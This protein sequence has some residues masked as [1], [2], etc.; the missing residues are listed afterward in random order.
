MHLHFFTACKMR[1]FLKWRRH[2]PNNTKHESKLHRFSQYFSRNAM[3]F[4]V[5]ISQ[6]FFRNSWMRP[7]RRWSPRTRE[8]Q[9]PWYGLVMK[10]L[11]KYW[12]WLIY[13]YIYMYIYIYSSS[14]TSLSGT[15]Q[16]LQLCLFVAVPFFGFG[17]AD[18]ATLVMQRVSE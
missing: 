18:N 10:S 17:F 8:L 9:A 6:F 1:H 13:I 15:S 16:L 3:A 11:Q 7:K 12:G 2:S 5:S 4:V 14:T